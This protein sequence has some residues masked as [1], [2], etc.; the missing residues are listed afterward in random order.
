MR[1]DGWCELDTFLEVQ[2]GMLAEANYDYAC[3]AVYP[4][5]PYGSITNGAPLTNETFT[6]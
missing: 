4:T 2:S 1:D 6:A 5:V 3:N